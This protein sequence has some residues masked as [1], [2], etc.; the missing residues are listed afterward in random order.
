[1]LSDPV[2]TASITRVGSL[3][4]VGLERRLLVRCGAGDW[5]P[6]EQVQIQG[7]SVV[8]AAVF[9]QAYLD[10]GIRRADQSAFYSETVIFESSQAPS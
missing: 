4:Y 6:V 5:L 9:A 8:S 3:V 1:M 7:K 10:Q 2:K